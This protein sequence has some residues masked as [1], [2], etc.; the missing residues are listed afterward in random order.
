MSTGMTTRMWQL[1]MCGIPS[2]FRCHRFELSSSRSWPATDD[3]LLALRPE[4]E[5]AFPDSCVSLAT[6][7]ALHY[8]LHPREVPMSVRANE[9]VAWFNGEFMPEREVRIPFRDSSWI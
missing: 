6:K 9:R 7:L 3:W 8:P 1:S 2:G 4:I 5:S